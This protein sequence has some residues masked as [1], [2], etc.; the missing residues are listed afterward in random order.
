MSFLRRLCQIT[1]IVIVALF[2]A[3]IASNAKVQAVGEQYTWESN[4]RIIACK[5][6]FDTCVVFDLSPGSPGASEIFTPQLVQEFSFRGCKI[7]SKG[8]TLTVDPTNNVARIVIN[9]NQTNNSTPPLG[10][11][12]C[13]TNDASK[14]MDESNITIGGTRTNPNPGTNTQVLS[15]TIRNGTAA[16]PATITVSIKAG[17]GQP[18][19]AQSVVSQQSN[20][21]KPIP[22]LEQY[23]YKGQFPLP[24]NKPYT[25]CAD[26]FG[27][28]DFDMPAGAHSVVIGEY[29]GDRVIGVNL[30]P[31]FKGKV[32]V[33]LLNA[34]GGTVLKTEELN[35]TPTA[36]TSAR[37]RAVFDNIDAGTYQACA[38]SVD[39][40]KC[41]DVTKTIQNAANV[42]LDLATAG[43]EAAEP[44]LRCEMEITNPIT[45]FVCPVIVG[46]QGGVNQ[47]SK[48]VDGMLELDA[49]SIF[50]KANSGDD[51]SEAKVGR[52]FYSAW[53]SFR[54][55]GIALILIA[56]LIM[57]ISQAAGIAL[58]DAYTIRKVLPRLV[59][60]TIFITISWPVLDFLVK[61]SNE[62]GLGVRSMIYY[63]FRDLS[64]DGINL[65]FG[66]QIGALIIGGGALF[67][68]GLIA[69]LSLVV[70]A[71]I[72]ILMGF[73]LL[74]ARE[75]V[76]MFLIIVSPFAIACSI[77]PNT[78]RIYELWRT[79][80][81]SALLLFPIIS[82]F[83][84][85]CRVFA[86][87]FYNA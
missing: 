6:G 34:T 80:L 53:K 63:P 26:G 7:K 1:S 61:L 30:G 37:T 56:G 84:A 12:Y 32:T 74:F 82:G 36:T 41:A 27:C 33:T 58:L 68:L 81:I 78:Q 10:P 16:S 51:S 15:Y 49:D 60:A 2:C 79:T 42:T 22:V 24:P 40:R 55:L 28:Q 87:V 31:G 3:N 47:L 8:V 23:E 44:G 19:S 46:A 14:V 59:I 86:V 38:E 48:G 67:V 21:V 45:Y 35:T 62:A 17:H 11:E 66:D 75:A 76:V 69:I 54:N 20:K 71:F 13:R 73:F 83:I 72:S 5:S 70:T 29:A 57:I 52:G 4:T 25:I 65:E 50:S 64:A 39:G 18:A 9:P 43:E 77:L 85:I